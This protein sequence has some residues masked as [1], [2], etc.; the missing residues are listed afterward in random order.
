LLDEA[1]SGKFEHIPVD[2]LWLSWLAWYA[3]VATELQAAGAAELLFERMRPYA[4]QIP[5]TDVTT[6]DPVSCYLAGLAVL[7]SHYEEAERYLEQAAGICARGSMRH[8]AA[9]TDLLW[10]RM[11]RARNRASDADH[12]RLLLVRARESA[13][14]YGYAAV[15]RRAAAELATLG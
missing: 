6:Q 5:T 2:F 7:L 15:E 3:E 9:Y 10:G 13:G 1:V 12:A 8:S 11:L 14:A 4:G